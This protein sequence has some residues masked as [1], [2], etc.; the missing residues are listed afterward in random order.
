MA[1]KTI[2]VTLIKS[3]IGTKAD[4]RATLRGLG[5]P[6]MNQTREL[7]DT[8]AVRGMITK[9]ANLV[10]AGIL[11]AQGAINYFSTRCGSE[12]RAS[13]PWSWCGFRL[14]QDGRSGPQGSKVPRRWLPQ[15]GLR[16]RSNA[17]ASS[18]AEAWFHVFD[19]SF[20]RRSSLERTPRFVCGRN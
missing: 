15:G 12:K 18:L 8:P 13:P 20:L 7:E 3:P 11:G 9:V 1:K 2:K 4:H 19:A 14:G 10:R 5:L 17:A 6:K 16:R